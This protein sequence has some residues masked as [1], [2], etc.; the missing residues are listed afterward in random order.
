[1]TTARGAPFYLSSTGTATALETA[2]TFSLFRSFSSVMSVPLCYVAS[3]SIAILPLVYALPARPRLLFI[4]I[5][6]T[7]N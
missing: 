1:M 5:E 7:E 2:L 3:L 4:L 6:L